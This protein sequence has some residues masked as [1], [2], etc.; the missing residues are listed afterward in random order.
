MGKK[1]K[2]NEVEQTPSPEVQVESKTQD[3]S[4]QSYVVLRAG[5]RVSEKEY[6][7]PKDSSALSELEFWKKVETNHSYGAPVEIVPYN[8]RR[9]RV[10]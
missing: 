6:S 1:V 3:G 4:Y 10:W 9:N 5:Y 8:P 7:D 2:S